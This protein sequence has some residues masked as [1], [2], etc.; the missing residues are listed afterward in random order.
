[1]SKRLIEALVSISAAMA[2]HPRDWSSDH[3]DAWVYGIVCGWGDEIDEV[4]AVHGWKDEDV[5]RLRRMRAEI[6][7][8]TGQSK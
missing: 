5:E 7:D 2:K 6:A 3:R 1:M 4:A 8:I